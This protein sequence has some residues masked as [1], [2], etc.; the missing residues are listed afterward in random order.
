MQHR[1][2]T[3]EPSRVGLVGADLVVNLDKALLD[4]EGNLTA[5]KGVLQT[6]AQ[7]DLWT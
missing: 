1:R 4:D 3:H 2:L 5:G 6:V 7:E